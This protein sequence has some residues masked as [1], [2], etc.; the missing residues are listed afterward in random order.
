MM[1]ELSVNVGVSMAVAICLVVLFFLAIYLCTPRI[2]CPKCGRR[3]MKHLDFGIFYDPAPERALYL[4]ENCGSELVRLHR[5]WI[6]RSEWDDPDDQ[7]LFDDLLRDYR[8]D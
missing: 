1:K 2:R 7:S 8:H 3:S 5:K 4:C 6:D